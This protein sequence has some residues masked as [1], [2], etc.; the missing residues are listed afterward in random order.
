MAERP[1]LYIDLDDTILA[2]CLGKG[3]DLRPG[4]LTQIDILSR[5]FSCY[6]LTHWQERELREL[7]YILYAGSRLRGI[8]YLNWRRNNTTN[9]AVTVV[10]G[11][12]DFYWLEDPLSTG[13]LKVLSERGVMD[14][15]IS[16]DPNGLWGFTRALRI[17]F[18]KA[19]ITDKDI[20]SSGG[21]PAWFKE[22]LGDHFDWTFYDNKR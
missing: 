18:D 20:I 2:Q 1:T 3:Y 6:W 14:R 4:V 15:Y 17:L 5:M 11:P 21:N 19:N 7:L 16:V 22:P 13:D 8:Q 9:K 10:L 12:K